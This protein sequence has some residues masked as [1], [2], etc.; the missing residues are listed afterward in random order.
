MQ[1]C[2]LRQ[3]SS[4]LTHCE[5]PARDKGDH[6]VVIVGQVPVPD[7]DVRLANLQAGVDLDGCN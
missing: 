5:V 4:L 3:I 2:I 6:G 1:G 7:P